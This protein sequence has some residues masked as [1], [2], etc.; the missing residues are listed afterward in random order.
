MMLINID[1]CPLIPEQD[2]LEANAPKIK[3]FGLAS[4]EPLPVIF[5]AAI[6]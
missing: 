4:V 3:Y 1:G 6:T 5:D 2:I